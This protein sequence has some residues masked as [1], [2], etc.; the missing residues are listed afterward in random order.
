MPEDTGD[1]IYDTSE[2][3]GRY[4]PIRSSPEEDV[5]DFRTDGEGPQGKK[6]ENT[7][8][9]SSRKINEPSR[10]G[11]VPYTGIFWGY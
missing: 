2:R 7:I 8:R 1:R 6:I 10:Y 9:R 4:E 3:D 11:G 5:I